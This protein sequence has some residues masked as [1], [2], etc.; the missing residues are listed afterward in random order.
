MLSINNT[1]PSLSVWYI[2]ACAHTHTHTHTHKSINNHGLAP[3]LALS[4]PLELVE[5]NCMGRVSLAACLHQ[6][7]PLHDTFTAHSCGSRWLTKVATTMKRQTNR[8]RERERKNA[9]TKTKGG[10]IKLSGVTLARQLSRD[11]YSSLTGGANV[12]L[13]VCVCVCVCVQGT[14]AKSPHWPMCRRM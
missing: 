8:E 6:R 4:I 10:H 3:A 5:L 9:Q 7:R 12:C 1:Y 14:S 11:R 2:C 13:F